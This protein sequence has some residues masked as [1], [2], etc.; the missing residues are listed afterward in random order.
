[1]TS[2]DYDVV[3]A[4]IEAGPTALKT[5]RSAGF[6]PEMFEID[7]CKEIFDFIKDFQSKFSDIPKRETVEDNFD[8]IGDAPLESLPFYLDKMKQREKFKVIAT[9]NNQ[10]A[11]LLNVTDEKDFNEGIAKAEQAIRSASKELVTKYSN[12]NTGDVMMMGD[13]LK[14]VYL[15][16]KRSDGIIGIPTY[17]PSLTLQT[18]GFQGGHLYMFLAP[19]GTGKTFNLL[20]QAIAAIRAGK[21]VLIYTEEMTR[22]ELAVRFVSLYFKVPY[23]DVLDGK[24][25]PEAEREYFDLLDTLHDQTVGASPVEF[26]VNQGGGVEGFDYIEEMAEEVQPDIIIIDNV[27]LYSK[28]GTDRE[29]LTEISNRAKR[30]AMKMHVPIVF[31]TQMNDKGDAFGSRAFGFDVTGRY[32]MVK[33]EFDDRMI[34]TNTKARDSE[35]GLTFEVVW[36]FLRM[37]FE[38]VI[39]K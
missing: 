4:M 38:E 13:R 37:I 10:V 8:D 23:G 27:Y 30:L 12:A 20:L 39:K 7:Q 16:A 21:K 19:E 1:M 36:D 5:I 33:D 31:C 34:F 28:K 18:R 11:N 14:E 3:N 32:Q 26:L 9:L 6:D 15:E 17:F 35:G 24:L 25:S 2:L 22:E 29:A